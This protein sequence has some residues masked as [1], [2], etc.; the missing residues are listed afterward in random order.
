MTP[1]LTPPLLRRHPLLRFLALNMA[2][3]LV[4]A[5]LAVGGLIGLDL[6]GLRRLIF[7]DHSPV[8]ALAL[9]AGG[10]IV[11][12]A[13]TVMGSA[14]MGLGIKPPRDRS[15]ATAPTDAAAVAVAQV[16]RPH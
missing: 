3:G 7:A 5:A 1:S 16:R 15:G 13:S 9:F 4:V 10:F 14:I 11:T 12:F 6:F 2:L 8:A